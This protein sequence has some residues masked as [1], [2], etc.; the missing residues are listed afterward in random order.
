MCKE[1]STILAIECKLGTAPD[2]RAGAAQGKGRK[3]EKK[4]K[5]E[6]D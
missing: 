3:G 5:E 6:K 4:K 2:R 1:P